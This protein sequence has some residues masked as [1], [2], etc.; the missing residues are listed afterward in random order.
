VASDGSR[1]LLIPDF[2]APYSSDVNRHASRVKPAQP[3]KVRYVVVTIAVAGQLFV[4]WRY[5]L[6]GLSGGADAPIQWMPLS[7]VQEQARII[8]VSHAGGARLSALAQLAG[9]LLML[10][11]T[12]LA[13]ALLR[14]LRWHVIAIVSI[15]LSSA[16]E[17]YQWLA[18]T[19]R[20][21]DVDDVLL[22]S[23]GCVLVFAATRRARRKHHL[24]E[25]A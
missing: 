10:G 8:L 23:V 11:P 9:N 3:P 14:S 16:V 6:G 25:S 2:E 7:T 15:A 18:S 17:T 13:V 1:R 21:A 5:A 12:G 22:N 24:V 20:T 4:L 19:G